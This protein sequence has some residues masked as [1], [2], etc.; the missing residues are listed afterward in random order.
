M[1][2]HTVQVHDFAIHSILHLDTFFFFLY[3]SQQIWG[4]NKWMPTSYFIFSVIKTKII[5][6]K[7]TE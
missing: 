1:W 5:S 7:Q 4:D 3:D 6:S 2:K